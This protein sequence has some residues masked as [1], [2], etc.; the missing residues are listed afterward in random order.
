MIFLDIETQAT[1]DPAVIK[2]VTDAVKPPGQYKKPESIA[3]WMRTEGVAAKLEAIGRTALDG[4]YGSIVSVAYAVDKGEIQV[5]TTQD[6]TEAELLEKLRINFLSSL[7]C[8]FNGEFDFRF[9]FQRYVVNNLAVPYLPRSSKD[10]YDPMVEWAGYRGFIKQQELEQALGI[11]RDD[12]LTGADVGTALLA[13]DWAAV[14]Q[15]NKEDVRCLREIYWR[16]TK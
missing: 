2:R 15:H 11:V 8:A 14:V 16:M 13:G 12:K 1:T 10:F 7:F 6:I 3:E 5:L 4:T 9:I